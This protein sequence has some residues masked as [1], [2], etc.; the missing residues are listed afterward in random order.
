[1]EEKITI[2]KETLK[3]I[4]VDSR[5][6]ILK[7][8]SQ[9]SYILSD[10]AIEL[11]L[12]KPTIK[13]HLKVLEDANLI[14]KEKTTRKW[15]YYSLTFKGRRLIQPREVKVLFAFMITLVSA[16]GFSIAFVRRMFGGFIHSEAMFAT[17]SAIRSFA[18]PEA[19]EIMVTN[20]AMD[21]GIMIAEDTIS[22][23]VLSAQPAISSSTGI[24]SD[25][26]TL[27]LMFMCFC[28]IM[29]STFLLGYLSHKKTIII[30][31]KKK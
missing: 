9:K 5:L 11:S 25:S 26:T 19:A 10:I 8:L 27:F 7:L 3:A 2:D 14:E 31:N 20:D 21:T 24:F 28:L 23:A 13:E 17:K 22:Q 29:A 30:T 18:V 12:S 1:M 4:A 15:K 6:N 16:I